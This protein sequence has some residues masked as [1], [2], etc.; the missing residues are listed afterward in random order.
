MDMIFHDEDDQEL[1]DETMSIFTEEYGSPL[2]SV[3]LLID[4]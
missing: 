2:G 4:G 3:S 1:K